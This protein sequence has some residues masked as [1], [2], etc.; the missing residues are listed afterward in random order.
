MN[1]SSTKHTP[2]LRKGE[3]RHSK[4]TF[5]YR[6]TDEAGERHSVYAQTLEELRQKEAEIEQDERDRIKAEA[7]NVTVN[8]MFILWKQ[9]KRGLKDNTFQNYQYMY[10]QFVAPSFGQKRISTLLK[11]D[12]KRFYNTL[13]DERWLSISTIDNVHTVLHQVLDMAVDDMYIRRNPSDNVMKELKQSFASRNEKRRALTKQEQD[14]F[15]HYLRRSEKYQHWYP[16]FAIMIGTGLRVGEAVGLRWC[17]I[18]LENGT[19]DVNHTLVYYRHAVNGCY[20]NVHTPKTV[21]GIRQVPMLEFVKAAFQEEKQRQATEGVRCEATVDGYTDFIFVNRFGQ[22]QHQGT[23]NKALRRI[24]RD[25]NDEIMLKGKK[26]ALMLPHFSCHSLRH[27]FTTRLCEAGVNIK[28]IQ[29][30]L[31]HADVSTTL[32]I[33]AD[34]TRELKANEFKNFEAFWS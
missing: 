29:D 33:Y 1:T 31:G 15:L 4:G 24:V 5:Q 10:N 3:S 28:V 25:C 17:D 34:A 22:P 19:I 7:R 23:L 11:S 30:A 12:V 26:D 21:N 2:I 27:T 6:W 20:C 8:D 9:L 13:A 18:D 16:V 32:N 14:L